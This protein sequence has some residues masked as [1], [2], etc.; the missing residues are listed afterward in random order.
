MRKKAIILEVFKYF[1]VAVFAFFIV[2]FPLWTVV[3]NS[4]K[5]LAEAKLLTAGLPEHSQFIENYSVAL[6]EGN[7]FRTFLNT[8]FITV[9]CVVIII[10]LGSLAAWVFARNKSRLVNILYFVAITGILI[11]APIVT[12]LKLLKSLHIYGGYPGL[13]LF[14]IG[15][16]MSF[17]I[18]F[19]TGFIKTI[20]KELEEAAKIDGCSHIGIY[21]RIILP[22]L[23]PVIATSSIILVLMIW[24]DFIYALYLLRSSSDWTLTLGLFNFSS[25]VFRQVNWHLV[26]ANVVLVSLPL[27]IFYFIAQ[28]WI[29]SGI[30]RGGVKG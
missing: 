14:Y 10:F 18:F 13:I 23:V 2:I 25:K 7:Y 28:R 30:M 12:S 29:I 15:V 3:V 5:P 26:Y 21:F 27:L 20:P 22:L 24:N 6:S 11:P 4:G 9:T 16:F 1:F 19:I 17:A 8:L